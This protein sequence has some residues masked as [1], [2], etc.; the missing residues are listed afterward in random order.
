MVK[1]LIL[2]DLNSFECIGSKCSY[3]CC[4]DWKISVDSASARFYR[5]VW[6]KFGEELKNGI[7][8]KEGNSYF[9]LNE[10]RCPFLNEDSLC[11]I[12]IHLGADHL[13]DTCKV[14]PR[15]NWVYGDLTFVGKA[16]SCPEVA[17]ILFESAAPLPFGFS[18]DVSVSNEDVDWTVFNLYVKGMTTSIEIL[19]N[20]ELDFTVRMRAVL[21]FNYYFEKYLN[22][23]NDCTELF[24]MFSST[25]SILALTEKLNHLNTN[26][27]SRIALFLAV[28]QN[29]SEILDNK[30]IIEY[31]SFGVNYLQKPKENAGLKIEQFWS[32]KN[33]L[34]NKIDMGHIHE[35][36]GV[37]YISMYYMN[38]FKDK[39]PYKFMVQFFTLFYLQNCFEAFVYNKNMENL[40]LNDLIEIYTKTA[41]TYEH[42][43]ENKNMETTF[44]V[45]EKNEMTSLAFLMSLV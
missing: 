40:A 7:I 44:S 26:Y 19:Q 39:Q 41:R 14:Y 8:D 12:Y 42:S 30:P 25:D 37:Y 43:S 45:L 24:D 16:I 28:A 23:D 22:S 18:E 13:C 36:Y 6:G 29:I 9:Q 5:N 33:C 32:D 27:D 10:G 11:D 21:L 3:T 2:D 31:I 35:Q 17:R 15:R 34:E 1:Y 38:S 4:K 20:H